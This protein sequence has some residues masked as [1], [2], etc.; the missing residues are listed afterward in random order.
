MDGGYIWGLGPLKIG[1][2]GQ[3]VFDKSKGSSYS[4]KSD[5]VEI[6]TSV[7]IEASNVRLSDFNEAVNLL[8][9][10]RPAIENADISK[11][12]GKGGNLFG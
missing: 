11:I 7:N 5:I 10:I 3:S 1:D 4:R 6:V 12:H 8:N 2:R 9:R